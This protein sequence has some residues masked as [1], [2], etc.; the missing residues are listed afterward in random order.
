MDGGAP[1]IKVSVRSPGE[2]KGSA[3]VCFEDNT[4]RV[5]IGET[6]P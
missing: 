1:E 4:A 5:P 2:V 3:A 6:R